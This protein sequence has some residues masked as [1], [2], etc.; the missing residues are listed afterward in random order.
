MTE[1]YDGELTRAV[2]VDLVKNACTA[3]VSIFLMDVMDLYDECLAWK[4]EEITPE[5][6]EVFLEKIQILEKHVEMTKRGL[7]QLYSVTT[8]DVLTL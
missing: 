1:K 2:R 6:K 7:K 5:Y 4:N 3:Q 8:G